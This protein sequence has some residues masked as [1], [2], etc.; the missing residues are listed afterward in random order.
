MTTPSTISLQH[1]DKLYIN[2]QWLAPEE[3]GRLEIVSPHLEEVTAVTGEAGFADMDKAVAAA[4]NAFDNSGWPQLSSE[5]RAGYLRKLHEELGKR[6][7]ELSDA[8]T[9]Q[10]GTLAPG[11]HMM[12]G[13]ALHLLDYYASGANN[14]KFVEEATAAD[15]QSTALIAHEAVGVVVTIAPWNAP[16]TTLMNKLA[17]A[18]LAGCTVILKPAPE[19]P[20]EAYILAEA[21]DAAGFPAGVVNMVAANREASNHLISNLDVDKVSF[22]GSTEAGK[23]IGSVCAE[24]IGRCTLELGGKSAAIILDDFDLGHAAKMLAN[25]IVIATGQV[26][27]T[28]SR[29]IVSKHRQEELVAL[30]KQELESIKVGDPYDPESQM[31][32]LAMK[33]Q[34]ERVESYV[35][36]GVK[37][38]ATLVSGGNRPEHMTSGYYF[39]PTLFSN[40]SSSMTIA[41]EE[42]FGPV[43]CV[44]PCED[45]ADAIRIANDSQYG[46]YGGVLTSD[47]DKAYKIARSIRTGAFAQ[48]GFKLDF[49]LPFG[50][51]KQSGIGREGGHSGLTTYTETKTILLDAMP[52]SL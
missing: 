51:F 11:G 5:E 23:K 44:L 48:N 8:L 34:L 27:A 24:R 40:V 52:S 10:T 4:R 39:N 35:E 15:G 21:A 33:R 18:L 29:V 19:T 20:I 14:F 37:E 28:L 9:M 17:P 2:G 41:Q 7:A 47:N 38:G 1:A 6:A 42:I 32:P 31:G 12:T 43:L 13:L 22:T 25:V 16:L 46:L 50:G 26:C 45:E 36:I 30:L 3:G 49:F